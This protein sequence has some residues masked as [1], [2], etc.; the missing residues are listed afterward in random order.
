MFDAGIKENDIDIIKA[1]NDILLYYASANNMEKLNKKQ[2]VIN[3]F[4]SYSNSR[5]E[6]E[7]EE[8]V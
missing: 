3:D 8:K 7:E 2:E 5:L 4:F 1:L 6:E